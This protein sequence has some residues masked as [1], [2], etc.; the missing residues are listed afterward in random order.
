MRI[1][2]VGKAPADGAAGDEIFD[3]KI[4]SALRAEGVEPIRVAPERV[5]KPREILNLLRCVPH[6]RARYASRRNHDLL[7]RTAQECDVAL[8]SW[9][10]FDALAYRLPCPVIPILHNVT[11]RSL[12]SMFPR[13]KAAALAAFRAGLWEKH[14]YSSSR[15]PAIAVL[16]RQDQAH[17][18]S[19]APGKHVLFTPPGMPPLVPLVETAVFKPEILISGTYDWLPKHRDI[20]AFAEEYGRSALR[21]PILANGLPAKAAGL[22]QPEA[23]P[24]QPPGDAIRLGLIPDRFD[25]GHKLKTTY[26]IA[27]NA[28]VLSYANVLF[29]F[30]DIEDHAFF[31]RKISRVD[32]I[33]RHIREISLVPP[34][35][36]RRR[37]TAFKQRCADKFSWALAARTLL[38][39]ID[40]IAGASH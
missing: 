16:S 13:N 33:D 14:I 39:E 7:R 22:L 4:L 8:C 34:E 25:A 21:L 18:E 12:P 11:S 5:S 28:I 17:V 10:P 20:V 6:Y 29:D 35:D 15:F 23:L 37:L 36:L 40:S 31:I 19:L 27:S 24:E 3:R 32:E 38:N 26:Y 30:A 1:L 2:W 9:E